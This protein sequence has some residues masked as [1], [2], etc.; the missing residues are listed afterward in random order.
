MRAALSVLEIDSC[1]TVMRQ[2]IFATIG[3]IDLL[4]HVSLC[5]AGLYPHLSSAF[6]VYIADSNSQGDVTGSAL[7]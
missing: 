7:Q 1:K 2:G 5:L 6:A 3:N 4:S